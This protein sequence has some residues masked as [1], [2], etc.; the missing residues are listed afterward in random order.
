MAWDGCISAAVLEAFKKA[1]EGSTGTIEVDRLK[2]LMKGLDPTF[3]DE[4]LESF[5]AWAV[6]THSKG[7][8]IIDYTAL[9]ASLGTD[10]PDS[11]SAAAPGNAG[12]V[13]RLQSELIEARREVKS[14]RNV[15]RRR[16][17]SFTVGQ[18]NILAG[19]LGNNMEPWFLYGVDMPPERRAAI[20]AKHGERGPDG[21]HC[22][23]GWPNYVNGILSEVEQAAVKREHDKVFAWEQRKDK[24]L[25]VIEDMDA[26][27]LSLV[28]CDHYEDHFKPALEAMGYES[29]WQK[30]PRKSS[31]DGCCIAWNSSI[32][33]KVAS[34]SCEYVDRVCDETQRLSKDRVALLVLVRV[35]ITGQLFVM[36]S[37]HL[38]RN[39][40]DPK[41]DFLRARQV[42]QVIQSLAMFAQEHDAMHAPVICAGDMN[43]T[44]FER[45]RGL[46][47]VVAIMKQYPLVHPFSFDCA[48]VPS[49]PTSVTSSRCSRI[50]AIL[51]QS[52]MLELVDMHE[53]P[54]LSMKS[55][56]P[57]ETHPSDHLPVVA[58]FTM[59][60]NLHLTYQL[61]K[62]WFW[63]TAGRRGALP[64]DAWQLHKSW[65]VFDYDGFGHC[66][67]EDLHKVVHRI[68]GFVP[69]ELDVLLETLPDEGLDYKTFVGCYH[70]ALIDK[71]LPGIQDFRAAF[72]AFDNDGDELID[73]EELIEVLRV[74]SPIPGGDDSVIKA[75]A[76]MDKNEDGKVS[77]AEL[78]RYLADAWVKRQTQRK[79]TS[80][81]EFKEASGAFLV[82]PVEVCPL[83]VLKRFGTPHLA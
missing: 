34:N 71:G 63:V 4:W 67:L 33:E 37:T 6:G 24:L 47:N 5:S 14:L 59:R 9:V 29:V 49:G 38:T 61:A 2:T 35:R 62:D 64:L 75:F 50:D 52:H 81:L 23:V 3:T 53:L 12:E 77:F 76:S 57:N 72:G 36:V 13:K 44:S 74:S 22:N 68:F 7:E 25:T 70:D 17:F 66:S 42:G 65:T 58:Q 80:I 16:P 41:Q 8:A 60:S 40:E 32:F 43:C 48:D 54:D 27:L 82:K 30:R 31:A 51:Y 78:L 73:L 55:P 20:V 15:I 56:I 28:E 69:P 11:Q 79:R 10:A 1:D 19:Y 18:Y 21:K 45:L 83:K 46:A 39:P 26:D